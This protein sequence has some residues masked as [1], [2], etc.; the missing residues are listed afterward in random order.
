MHAFLSA[1][2]CECELSQ[3]PAAHFP[4]EMDCSLDCEIK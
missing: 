3:A 1:L 4:A 2:D